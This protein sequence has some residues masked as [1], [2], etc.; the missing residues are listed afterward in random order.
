M[1]S[2]TAGPTTMAAVTSFWVAW[3]TTG[4]CSAMSIGSEA[5]IGSGATSREPTVPPE[6]PRRMRQGHTGWPHG[7]G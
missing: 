3:T 4:A 5:A 7:A 1:A 6:A 2:A